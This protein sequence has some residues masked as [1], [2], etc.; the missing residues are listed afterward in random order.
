MTD[1][2][3]PPKDWLL[4]ICLVSRTSQGKQKQALLISLSY[5]KYTHMDRKEGN[6]PFFIHLHQD[7]ELCVELEAY[8][9]AH[10][11]SAMCVIHALQV[12]TQLLSPGPVLRNAAGAAAWRWEARGAWL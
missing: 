6:T 1:V 12:N 7:Y 9:C 8:I 2:L 4:H 10:L 11:C 3:R 5:S